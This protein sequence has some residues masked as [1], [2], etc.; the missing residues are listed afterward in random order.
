MSR[1]SLEPL[2]NGNIPEFACGPLTKPR[3]INPKIEKE[4]VEFK[5]EIN[6]KFWQSKINHS[7]SF[8][9]PLLHKPRTTSNGPKPTPDPPQVLFKAPRGRNLTQVAVS[10]EVPKPVP[11]DLSSNASRYAPV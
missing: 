4:L 1:K 2:S 10:M 8:P 11:R 3:Y 7:Y 5:M 6:D 9:R